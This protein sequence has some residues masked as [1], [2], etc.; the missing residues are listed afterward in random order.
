MVVGGMGAG[1]QKRGSKKVHGRASICW[2][3]LDLTSGTTARPFPS[4]TEHSYCIVLVTCLPE[5]CRTH[6]LQSRNEFRGAEACLFSA[7]QPRI[8][9]KQL[10]VQFVIIMDKCRADL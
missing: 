3:T 4:D 10:L 6:G 9:V 8:V 5:T 1:G 2:R 7:M